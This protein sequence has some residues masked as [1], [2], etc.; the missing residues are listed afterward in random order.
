M[1]PSLRS[2]PRIFSASQ[3]ETLH[4]LNANSLSSPL[5]LWKPSF[6]FLFLNLTT[7]GI[8]YIEPYNV[9]PFVTGLFPL[10]CLQDQL[11]CVASCVSI[12]FLLR[13]NNILWIDGPHG[14]YFF[15]DWET[16]LLWHHY[17]TQSNLQTHCNPY[18]KLNRHLRCF[19]ILVTVNNIIMNSYKCLFENLFFFGFW[20][21]KVKLLD[22]MVILCLIFLWNHHSVF[23]SSRLG[24][25][26]H[27]Q[28]ITVLISPH[29]Y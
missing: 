27:K 13:L 24:L 3:T 28:G 11:I 19:H 12:L 21:L 16:V 22:H 15:M 9:S 6:Y 18:Q 26:S 1:Q 4:P 25:H 5:S 23:H 8:S 17:T 20:Y 2:I 29:F 14:V 7:L 10:T